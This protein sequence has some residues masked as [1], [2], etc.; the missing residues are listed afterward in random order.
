MVL[1]NVD[2]QRIAVPSVEYNRILIGERRSNVLELYL[3]LNLLKLQ[4][5]EIYIQ[6]VGE[7]GT[8]F[9]TLPIAQ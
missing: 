9:V 3:A 2:L 6:R 4:K 5:G 1:T 8:L 7:A